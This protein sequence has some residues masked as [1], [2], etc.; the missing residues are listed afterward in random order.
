MLRDQN[1]RFHMEA[2]RQGSRTNGRE[3]S[4]ERSDKRL[5]AGT[6]QSDSRRKQGNYFK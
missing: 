5:M 3:G 1:T 6:S 2:A 4:K